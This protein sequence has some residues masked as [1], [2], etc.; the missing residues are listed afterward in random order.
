MAGQVNPRGNKAIVKEINQPSAPNAG[1][2]MPAG[3]PDNENDALHQASSVPTSGKAKDLAGKEDKGAAKRALDAQLGRG[4]KSMS[5]TGG[6]LGDATT[7][8]NAGVNDGWEDN[9]QK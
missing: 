9:W 8:P 1:A 5:K 2:T 3:K 7:Q 4:D 6:R